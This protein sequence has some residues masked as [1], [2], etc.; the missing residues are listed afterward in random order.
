[1]DDKAKDF[2]EAFK[3]GKISRRELMRGAGKAR[4]QRRDRQF[5]A[6]RRRTQ[7]LAADFDWKKFNG[8]EASSAA[9]QASL[10]GRDDRRS[11]QLQGR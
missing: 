8:D 11:R 5:H 6:Q 1:M 10:R 3:A 9:Q 2:F 7:A 4:R